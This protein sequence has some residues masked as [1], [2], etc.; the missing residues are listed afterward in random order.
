MGTVH[1]AN[2]DIRP[3]CTRSLFSMQCPKRMQSAYNVILAKLYCDTLICET[4]MHEDQQL[5]VV[6]CFEH[7]SVAAGDA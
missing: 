4:C 1:Q 5:T 2:L 6:G 3:S 7:A